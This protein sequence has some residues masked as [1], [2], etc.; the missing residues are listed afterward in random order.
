MSKPSARP[1]HASAPHPQTGQCV[2]TNAQGRVVTVATNLADATFI[3]EAVALADALARCVP[4]EIFVSDR[5]YHARQ[6]IDLL[7]AIEPSAP[8]PAAAIIAL[9]KRVREEQRNA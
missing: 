8:T 6:W 9:A 7:H 2:I 4:F 5:G 1:W 3:C